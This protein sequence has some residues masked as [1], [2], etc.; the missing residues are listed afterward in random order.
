MPGLNVAGGDDL[1]R[2]LQNLGDRAPGVLAEGVWRGE[3]KVEREAKRRCP[4][5]VS[6]PGYTGGRLRN[7]ITAEEPV[8]G[9]NRVSG[10]VGT[11]VEYAPFVEYGTGRRGDAS[12]VEHPDDYIYGPKPGMDAQ[13]FLRPA[14]DENADKIRRIIAAGIQ[15]ALRREGV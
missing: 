4:V 10:V 8:A 12:G 14:L 11:N 3:L 2:R 15:D 5:G 7:S 9:G 13:P 6:R 1:I